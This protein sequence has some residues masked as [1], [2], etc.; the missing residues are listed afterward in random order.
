MG[1]SACLERNHCET[2]DRVTPAIRAS[3][4]CDFPRRELP[5]GESKKSE[6][7]SEALPLK[8]PRIDT[9]VP[10]FPRIPAKNNVEA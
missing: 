1:T 6:K 4:D 2:A 5:S 10:F 3:S 8:G 7:T 9:G